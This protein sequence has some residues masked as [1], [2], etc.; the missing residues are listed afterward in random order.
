[1]IFATLETAVVALPLLLASAVLAWCASLVVGKVSFVDWLWPLFMVAAAGS[2]FAAAGLTGPRAIVVAVLLVA[3]ALRLSVHIAVRNHGEPED[4]RYRA[5]RERRPYFAIRSLYVVFV[6]QALLAWFVALPLAAVI[7]GASPA[8]RSA[9]TPLDALGVLLWVAGMLFEVGGDRQLARFRKDP[10]NAGRVLD[11]G[12]WRYTRHPNYFGEFCIW[13]AFYLFAL[14][15]GG[16]WTVA[17]PV[18]MT[19]L[20]LRVSGVALLE[21]TITDRRP[22]YA[23]YQQRT[24]AFFPGPPRHGAGEAAS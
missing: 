3:W 5:M 18:L 17:S 16:W 20:L 14:A 10:A 23:D 11:T 6:L 9:L 13:W 19:I 2:W 22:G 7:A 4:E 15:A 24:N 12:L 8:A 21:R 1:M